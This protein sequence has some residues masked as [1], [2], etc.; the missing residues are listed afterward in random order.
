MRDAAFRPFVRHDR[1]DHA[2][3]GGDAA[4][5]QAFD[6]HA[7]IAH[8]RGD[9]GEHAHLVLD[10]EAQIGPRAPLAAVRLGLCGQ[11]GGGH[12]IGRAELAAGNVDQVGDHRARGRPFARTGALEE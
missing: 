8:R 3:V 11:R 12:C 9:L 6:R 2:A 10:G 5:D 1:D 4:L 7:G